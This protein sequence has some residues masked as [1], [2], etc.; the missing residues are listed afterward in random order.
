MEEN[1][2]IEEQVTHAILND[3]VRYD[4]N[5]E[6]ITIRPLLFGAILMIC[7]RVCQAGLTLKEIESGENNT[8]AFLVKYESL[9]LDC[10]AIA[11]LGKKEDL[12]ENK[13]AKRTA[14]YR[15]NLTA[16]QIYELFAFVL[17]LSGVESFTNTIRLIWMTKQI[18]L[19]PKRKES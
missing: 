15:D 16:Y 6:K 18:N 9:M 12:T 8:P 14:W 2:K 11:E 10:V 5:G 13:I 7:Q 17:K 19:S 3:G 4:L 1:L